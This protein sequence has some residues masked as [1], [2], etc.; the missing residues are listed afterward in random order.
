MKLLMITVLGLLLS[1]CTTRGNLVTN[2]SSAWI[3]VENGA[4][5]ELMYCDVKS[6]HPVCQEPLILIPKDNQ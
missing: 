5:D 6:G 4:I 2:N 1:A 3:N